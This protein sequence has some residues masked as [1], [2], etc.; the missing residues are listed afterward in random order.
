MSTK[1]KSNNTNKKNNT[2]AKKVERIVE[3]KTVNEDSN[4]TSLSVIKKEDLD[5][6]IEEDLGIKNNNTVKKNNH[7]IT[8][9]ILCIVL[10]VSIVFFVLNVLDNKSSITT[11]ISSLIITLFSI[12]YSVIGI[13]YHR[14]NKIIIFISG[15]LLLAFFGLNIFK[16]KTYISDISSVEDFTGKDLTYVVKWASKNN[17]TLN[18]D[19]EYSDMIEEYKIISQ[20]SPNGTKLKDIS[21]L[22]ISISEGPNPYKEIVV[23]SMLTWNAD[24]V[25]NFVEDNHLSNVIVEFVSSDKVKDTVI[26]QS[27]SGNLRRDDELKITFSYGEELGFDE[28]KLIDFTNMS[29]FRIEFYMKQ[30]Q[31]NYDFDYDF[32][33]KVKRDHGIKQSIKSGEAVH[34]NGDRIT[35]TLSKGPEIKVPDTSKMSI[36]ELTEWA[37]KNRIKLEFIDKYDDSVKEGEII[38]IDKNTGDIIEQRSTIKVSLSRGKLKM[39]K[40]SSYDDFKSWADKY[41]IKYEEKREFNNKVKA[42]EVISYSYKSG[43]TIKNGDTIIVTISDGAKVTV[44][45]LKGLNKND[46]ISKLKKAGLNYSFR[47]QSSNSTKDTVI[48]QSISSGSEVSS[49]TTI[50]VTLSSGKNSNNN[51]NNNNNNNNNGSN[52]NPHTN[53]DSEPDPEPEQPKPVCNSCTILRSY[54]S[55][56][57]DGKETCN[58]AKNSLISSLQSRCPGLTVI[59]NCVDKDGYNTNDFITKFIGETN[60]CSTVSYTLAN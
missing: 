35:I 53:P 4:T 8:N 22:K 44:P 59:V 45:N 39:P 57:V 16:N 41:E 23:P 50:S 54:V 19:Y 34:V 13:T 15:L 32:S 14:K 11:I 29:K 51:G 38:G 5:D 52:T 10:V 56:A 58:E 26:E 25:I 43:D 27:K 30:N 7:I 49:G 20:D 60:S 17:I 1:K 48:S 42:G 12:I 28:V 33:N 2:N 21:E 47:Y 36:T 46:A 18:Q 55:N 9:F 31:L 3:E 37:V 6:F 40:F 24:R